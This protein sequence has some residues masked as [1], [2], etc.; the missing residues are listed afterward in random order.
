MK[1]MYSFEELKNEIKQQLSKLAGKEFED[2]H[3]ITPPKREL[4]DLSSNICFEIAKKQNKNPN[5]IA[6]E[7]ASK[8]NK[9][10][11]KGIKEVKAADAYV[12]FF[13][14]YS[15][16]S[17][18]VLEEAVKEDYGSSKIGQGKTIFIDYS[19]V[20]IAK[21]MHVGHLRSTII[22]NSLYKLLEYTGFNCFGEN[23]LGDW[24]LQF[25]KLLYAYKQWGSEEELEKNPIQH[26]H[27]LYVK[28]HEL[29]EKDASLKLKAEEEFSKLEK[30]D[31]QNKEL[32]K[33]FKEASLEKFEKVYKRLGIEFDSY[34]G[35]AYYSQFTE[36]IISEAL[37]KKVAV[38]EK[39]GTVV[40]PLEEFGLTNA[41]LMDNNRTLYIAREIA[42]AEKRKQEHN[43]YKA[44]YVVSSAQSLH[45][46]QLKKSLELLGYEWN[47]DIEH[48]KFGLFSLPEGKLSTRKGRIIYL[49]DVLDKAVEKALE[50]INEKNSSLKNKSQVA[51]VIGVGAVKFGDLSQNK[52]KDVLF[53]FDKMVSFEGD[54]SPYLQYAYVRCNSILRKSN[55][56]E[57]SVDF[58]KLIESEEKQLIMKV[59]EFPVVVERSALKF[60]PHL[61]A[62]YLIELAHLF[63]VFYEKRK[64]AGNNER[65]FLVR[66]VANVL[67]IGLKLLGIGVIEEM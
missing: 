61:L 58:S 36:S 66:A 26:L 53:D 12:N 6:E 65:L 23:Y 9:A 18:K 13:I 35:E 32:W 4:G 57:Q 38:K 24:G 42:A 25:G 3:L 21:P 41:R 10:S 44:L 37:E 52:V 39:Q 51:E 29:E 7:I 19:S 49:N 48:V 43:F 64:V 5:K 60:E 15:W 56:D 34:N 59:A 40:I 14:N 30:G 28:F 45:F 11:I 63:S 55:F 17:E 54:T 31:K 2:I 46:Q 62:N 50:I 16:F 33:R 27:S 47:N 20:N 8:L 1:G 67:K 22:G